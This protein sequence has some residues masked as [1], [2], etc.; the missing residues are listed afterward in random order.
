[1]D[2]YFQI[3]VKLLYYVNILY[4]LCSAFLNQI[5]NDASFQVSHFLV[6]IV[7]LF[8]ITKY[9]ADKISRLRG[10][11]EHG[12]FWWVYTNRI[13]LNKHPHAQIKF[14]IVLWILISGQL[15]GHK[16]APTTSSNANEIARLI[17]D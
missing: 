3:I 7:R 4:K 9:D 5:L 17:R 8:K 15:L 14:G 10:N 16:R 11:Q 13:Q 2:N 6:N 1:M 12:L